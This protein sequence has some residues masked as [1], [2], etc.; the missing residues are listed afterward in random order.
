[1]ILVPALLISPSLAATAGSLIQTRFDRTPLHF[2]RIQAMVESQPMGAFNQW[3]A[4]VRPV[5]PDVRR[6]ARQ[7]RSDVD[8]AAYGL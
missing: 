3:V 7:L 5:R 6:N 8:Q 4:S 1:M 2:Q